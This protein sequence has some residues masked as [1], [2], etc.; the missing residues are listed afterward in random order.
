MIVGNFM[1]ERGSRAA[2][3]WYVDIGHMTVSLC[4]YI[5]ILEV[6][7]LNYPTAVVDKFM[8]NV[9]EPLSVCPQQIRI[10]EMLTLGD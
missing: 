10:R 5:C 6:D 9:M 8:N 7:S 3:L 1:T 4:L 2:I